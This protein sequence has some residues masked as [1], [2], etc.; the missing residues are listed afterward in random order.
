MS[1]ESAF[2]KLYTDIISAGFDVKKAPKKGDLYVYVKE[3]FPHFLVTDNS[4]FV[5]LYFT[6]KAVDDFKSS[7]PNVNIV[8]LKSK[9]LKVT[10]WSIEMAKSTSFTSYAG[11]EIKLI[12]NAVK[13]EK[14][15]I[16][17]Y[18]YP[19]NIYR[20][21]GIKTMILNQLHG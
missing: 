11:V 6:K 5:R 2:K 12:A 1:K 9:T 19:R 20:D 7:Y 14:K 8:D 4:Y 17:L 3:S 15:D 21:Q 16:P 18:T 10:D 13:V